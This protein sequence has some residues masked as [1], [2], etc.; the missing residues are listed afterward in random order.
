M[1]PV[2]NFIAGSFANDEVDV[3][4][5]LVEW[6]QTYVYDDYHYGKTNERFFLFSTIFQVELTHMPLIG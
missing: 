1:Y 6:H 3:G 4:G 5:A 2:M